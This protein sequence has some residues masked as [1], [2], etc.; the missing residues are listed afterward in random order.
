MKW[1]RQAKQKKTVAE[2]DPQPNQIQ[3]YK[4]KQYLY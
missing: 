1:Q 3:S 2:N 4:K